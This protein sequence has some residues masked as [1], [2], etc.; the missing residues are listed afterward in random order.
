MSISGTSGW[1]RIG[2]VYGLLDVLTFTD[3]KP[4]NLA[5][6]VQIEERAQ[7]RFDATNLDTAV[8]QEFEENINRYWLC[9]EFR[10]EKL[11]II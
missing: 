11:V 7:L 2:E 9:G 8:F 1:I 3:R 6:Y 10:F 5:T 4:R